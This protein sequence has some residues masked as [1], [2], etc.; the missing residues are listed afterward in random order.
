FYRRIMRPKGDCRREFLSCSTEVSPVVAEFYYE[1]VFAWGIVRIDADSSRPPLRL[2][3]AAGLPG[4]SLLGTAA[5]RWRRSTL[6]PLA[7]AARETATR[8]TRVEVEIWS[9]SA[10]LTRIN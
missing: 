7:S 10:T 9:R 8:M 4:A 5:R 6:P 1:G 2:A 3:W